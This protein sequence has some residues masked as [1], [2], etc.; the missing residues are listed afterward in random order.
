MLEELQYLGHCHWNNLRVFR[1]L[2]RNGK[3]E[4]V[5]CYNSHTFNNLTLFF[6]LVQLMKKLVKEELGTVAHLL[7]CFPLLARHFHNGLI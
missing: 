6:K 3:D 2:A 1:G 4:I 7:R 5:M